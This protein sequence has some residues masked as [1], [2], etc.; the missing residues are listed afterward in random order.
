MPCRTALRCRIS[1]LFW[2]RSPRTSVPLVP[3]GSAS[4]RW[5]RS[6]RP[7][8]TPSSMPSA[9]VWLACQLRPSGSLPLCSKP[10]H[11]GQSHISLLSDRAC[12]PLI[13]LFYAILYV[14]LEE[15]EEILHDLTCALGRVSFS[16]LYVL[17]NT[18]GHWLRQALN[19]LWA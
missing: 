14:D 8:P 3:K 13:A 17:K 6:A 4:R 2:L 19:L 11:S 1:R 12:F 7:L 10:Y 16:V 18:I 15:N 5:F 9:C